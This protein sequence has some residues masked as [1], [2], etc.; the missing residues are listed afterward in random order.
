MNVA[1]LQLEGLLIAVASINRTLVRSGVLQPGELDEAL[2]EAEACI[3]QDDRINEEM[4]PSNRDAVLFP[5]RL[6]Q[7]ANLHQSEPL[8]RTFSELARAVGQTK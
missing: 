6:L 7:L 2:R 1:N 5:V 3:T 4:S 8:A